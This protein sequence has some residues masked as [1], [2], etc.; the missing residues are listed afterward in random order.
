[1]S[2]VCQSDSRPLCILTILNI[3]SMS[4]TRLEVC[5]LI[6]T[7]PEESI[8]IL[9]SCSIVLA[10]DVATSSILDE[11]AAASHVPTIE[12]LWVQRSG[13][14]RLSIT[15]I[16]DAILSN[17]QRKEVLVS[18]IATNFTNAEVLP[19][20]RSIPEILTAAP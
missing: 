16:L 17:H 7:R 4:I 11:I 3:S 1:M 12:H 8:E 19:E 15:L 20:R 14:L 6:Y 2:R 5:D 18:Q 10:H 13:R 9:S